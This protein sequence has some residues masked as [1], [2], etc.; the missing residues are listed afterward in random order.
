MGDNDMLPDTALA[1]PLI[2]GLSRDLDADPS[3]S[4]RASHQAK[5]KRELGDFFDRQKTGSLADEAR[6]AR[7]SQK[8]LDEF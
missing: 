2:K 7:E 1:D 4:M 8:A 3:E 5:L 6:K